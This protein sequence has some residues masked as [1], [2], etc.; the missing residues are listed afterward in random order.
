MATNKDI[1]I[2]WTRE[3]LKSS[4][5]IFSDQFF[6]PFTEKQA[7][8]IRKELAMFKITAW[9]IPGNGAFICY[10][11]DARLTVLEVASDNSHPEIAVN[12]QRVGTWVDGQNIMLLPAIDVE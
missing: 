3:Q 8:Q 7:R 5:P 1:A 4:S 10:S 11:N 2:T 9:P 6:K 12:G